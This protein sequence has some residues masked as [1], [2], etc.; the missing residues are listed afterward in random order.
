MSGALKSVP[1]VRNAEV[2][3]AKKEAYVTVEKS[4]LDTQALIDAVKQAG[5]DASVKVPAAQVP[6]AP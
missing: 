4:K 1:G 2:D 3:F 5:Y 6:P